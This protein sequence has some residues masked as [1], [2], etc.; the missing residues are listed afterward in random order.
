MVW[1]FFNLQNKITL[2]RSLYTEEET[3][4][5]VAKGSVTVGQ[6]ADFFLPHCLVARRNYN[7]PKVA[8]SKVLTLS[9][10]TSEAQAEISTQFRGTTP[11][12]MFVYVGLYFLHLQMRLLSQAF[13]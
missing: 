3:G 5:P 7:Y 12:L 9:I 4:P 10:G 6:G 2:L 13:L 11:D 8:Q 1:T